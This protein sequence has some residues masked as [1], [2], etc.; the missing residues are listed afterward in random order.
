MDKILA[1]NTDLNKLW[2]ERG[3]ASNPFLNAS[4]KVCNASATLRIRQAP[5]TVL[6][7][8]AEDPLSGPGGD[9]FFN[10]R[11]FVPS[12]AALQEVAVTEDV[13]KLLVSNFDQQGLVRHMV[14]QCQAGQIL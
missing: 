8:S 2:V 13:L 6:E 10:L 9:S 12:P 14:K 1:A 11:R 5:R 4:F 7:G 3:R